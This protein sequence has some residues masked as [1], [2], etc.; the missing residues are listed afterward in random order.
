MNDDNKQWYDGL[1]LDEESLS[2]VQNK[3]WTDANSIIK[4]YRELE[5]FSGQ[6]KNDFIKIG[7]NE[8]GTFDYS[9]VYTKLGKPEK[10]EDYELSDS[11]FWNESREVLF[12]NGITKDQAKALQEFVDGYT[13]K[14][15]EAMER[16]YNE[17]FEGGLENLKKEWGSSFDANVELARGVVSELGIT[18]EQLD[19]IGD[20]MGVDK[21]ANMFLRMAKTTDADKPLTGYKQQSA[22]ATK[23]SASSRIAELQND[24]EFMKK[25]SEGDPKAVQEMMDLAKATVTV[26]LD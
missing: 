9:E 3:G 26:D 20:I 1:N 14:S 22:T 11:D 15:Q 8:D 2:T 10:A 25:V 17:K 16:E 4:S 7:K 6:D 5:K 18:D 19:R 24:P 12:K 21:I 23:E 13:V